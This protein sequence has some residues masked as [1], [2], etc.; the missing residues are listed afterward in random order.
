MKWQ[1]VHDDEWCLPPDSTKNGRQH[2]VYLSR[3]ARAILKKYQGGTHVFDNPES[4]TGIIRRDGVSARLQRALGVYRKGPEAS[5][6]NRLGVEPFCVHDLRRTLATWL[7]EN[8]VD[9][10][11]TD[12]ML[13]HYKKTVD[14]TYNVAKYNKPARKWWTNW[15]NHIQALSA[16]NVVPIKRTK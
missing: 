4:R 1:H 11:V 6:K 2:V 12:R 14:S 16:D 8:Q 9:G 10:R 15:G 7:G 13:N 5:R 3:Q